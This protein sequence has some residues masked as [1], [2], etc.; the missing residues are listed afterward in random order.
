MNVSVEGVGLPDSV[1]TD[2]ANVFVGQF[3]TALRSMYGI[4]NT[5]H[6]LPMVPVNGWADEKSEVRA[7]WCVLRDMLRQFVSNSAQWPR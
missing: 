6:Y 3:N 5:I 7:T 1:V 4:K 2:R